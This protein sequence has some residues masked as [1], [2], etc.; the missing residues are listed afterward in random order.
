MMI[1]GAVRW[2]RANT[3]GKQGVI[4]HTRH[5]VCHP[6]A[7]GYLIPSLVA[8]GSLDLA[9]QYARWLAA[10]QRP[11]GSFGNAAGEKSQ[12]FVTA[13]VVR[14]WVEMLA[15]LPE[16]E[17][18]L[19][20]ACD[21]IVA[22]SEPATGRLPVPEAGTAWNLWQRGEVS[23]AIHLYAL[24]PVERAGEL[25]GESRYPAFARK[26]LDYYLA[27]VPTGD[28]TSP[29]ALTHFYAYVQAALVELG[30]EERARRGMA[31][32]EPFQQD[33]GAVPAYHDVSWVCAPGLAHLALVW[34]HLGQ[35]ERAD[36]AMG[37]LVD[38]QRESGG[39]F[40]SAGPGATYFPD[41]EVPWA[42][43]YAID[44][45]LA[46]ASTK[47]SRGTAGPSGLAERRSI[48][49]PAVS[50][51]RKLRIVYYANCWMTN[52]GEAFIDIG[53]EQLLKQAAPDSE[54]ILLTPM[55]FHYNNAL[56]V[57]AKSSITKEECDS[58]TAHLGRYMD[59]D[60]FVMSGMYATEEYLAVGSANHWVNPF[61]ESHPHTKVLFMGVGGEKYTEQEV[62]A[63]TRYIQAKI[64]LAGFI[65]RDDDIYGLYRERIPDCHPGMDCAYFCGDIYAPKG[66]AN[67]EYVVSTFHSGPEPARVKD[68][69]CD[70]IRPEH[71]F[72]TAAYRP[73]R[74]NTFISDTPH[75]YLSLYANAR[76]VYT[77]LV[78]ATI[79]SLTYDVPVR[80]SGK[81]KRSQAFDAA[82][83]APNAAGFL[84]VSR[85]EFSRRKARMVDAVRH[86][87]NRV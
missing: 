1:D 12:A 74:Q 32:L 21:W 50:R 30:C 2:I 34:Y 80:Y 14:G 33:N 41:A 38:L 83:A 63:F 42:A 68:L 24:R 23:E 62:A 82:G 27:N 45:Y 25:L 10:I 18:P 37:H 9:A 16:L 75:E 67:K 85:E 47:F 39:F 72:H 17:G 56:R 78:H 87:L 73:N 26:A 22:A 64:N 6:E 65:S 53:A 71:M 58:R 31:A 15:D 35:H 70:V 86:A 84:T 79:V 36:R 55:S 13:Q 52:L 66:F 40:G 54:V 20:R 49:A 11:D 69:A 7:T 59:A 28:F 81:S 77:D 57:A 51:R 46:P 3:I 61:L 8:V 76:E 60:V 4:L 19:R 43:K 44:A 5:R 48:D 29:H